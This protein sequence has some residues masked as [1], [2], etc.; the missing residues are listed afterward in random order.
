MEIVA[1]TNYSKNDKSTAVINNGN[2]TS[3]NDE[4]KCRFK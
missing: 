3:N 4:S 1:N 2:G